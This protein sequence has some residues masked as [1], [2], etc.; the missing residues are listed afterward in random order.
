MSR[1]AKLLCLITAFSLCCGCSGGKPVPV[2]TTAK[3]ASPAETTLAET[4]TVT[5][6]SDNPDYNIEAEDF[7]EYGSIS[8][9][10][11]GQVFQKGFGKWN[12]HANSIKN[13]VGDTIYTEDQSYESRAFSGAISP[14]CGEEFINAV[15]NPCYDDFEYSYWYDDKQYKV[16]DITPESIVTGEEIMGCRSFDDVLVKYAF[17][18][19]TE[20]GYEF[21]IDPAC[22]DGIPLWT[23]DT[24]FMKFNVNGK[25]FYG[26]TIKITSGFSDTVSDIKTDEYVY[27]KVVFAYL[28]IS[29]STEN[30]YTCGADLYGI[31]TITEDTDAVIDRSFFDEHY[32]ND[33]LFSGLM[34]AEEEITN[35]SSSDSYF[36][37][38]LSLIDL[39]FDG[40]EEVLA[41]YC[42]LDSFFEYNPTK[43]YIAENGSL[44][45]AGDICINEIREGV[46]KGERGWVASYCDIEQNGN[47]FT[48][49]EEGH[50]FFTLKNGEIEKEVLHCSKYER[51][52]DK[53][54]YYY[55]GEEI[56][57]EITRF[58]N[59]YKETAMDIYEWK[60]FSAYGDIY[61]LHEKAA[62]SLVNSLYTPDSK[63]IFFSS[64]S[65]YSL[66]RLG[67]RTAAVNLFINSLIDKT[68][69]YDIMMADYVYAEIPA[70]KP[71]LYLYP[72]EE[73]TVDV[74]VSFPYGR[75]TCA[76]PEYNDGW[77]V[78]AMP[79]GTLFDKQGNEYYCLYWEGE[80]GK[81]P[82]MSKGFCVKGSDTAV[83]LREKLLSI[84]LTP[85][86]ANEFIIYWLPQMEDNEYNVISFH[87]DEYAEISPLEISPVPDTLIRV[88]MTWYESSSEI[89][90]QPQILP[91]YERKGFTAVEW[92]GGEIR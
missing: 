78:T 58:V 9:V 60:D 46:Y 92:G 64:D 3:E 56:V 87:T 25:E 15:N 68:K 66:D 44:T 69:D 23:T 5:G 57:P 8:E 51:E 47:I 38:R 53:V 7:P 28:N 24:R 4:T 34:N 75:L 2:D 84:G 54:T 31:E 27:A 67:Y 21:I 26:D 77:T 50:L 85:R 82:D 81:T 79:D 16:T 45:E 10:P 22:M 65:P 73:T 74:K 36:S 80:L 35:L 76:Y 13:V 32:G 71:V 11:I 43:I 40:K 83:F 55:L 14:E 48:R 62:E 89:Q 61:Y 59:P 1:K 19:K 49:R 29:F 90:L 6:T 88:F 39:D 72:E 37:T 41:H 20:G 70:E 17:V 86:E 18:R 33:P 30:G 12:I 91:Q 63:R 52:S 42:T